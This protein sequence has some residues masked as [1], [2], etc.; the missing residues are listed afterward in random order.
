ME[1]N[2]KRQEYYF[3]HKE[4]IINYVK[5]YNQEHKESKLLYYR[6]YYSINKEKI[7]RRRHKLKQDR[8]SDITLSITVSSIRNVSL[9]FD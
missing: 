9:S 2:N 3:K 7:I 8:Q 6:H 1:A 4:K 5:T